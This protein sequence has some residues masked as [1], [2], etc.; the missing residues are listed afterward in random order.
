MDYP[1]SPWNA[2]AA[3]GVASSLKAQGKT[4]EATTKYEDITKRFASSPIIDEAKLSLARLYEGS[5]A[6]E[7][8]KLYDDLMKGNPRQTEGFFHGI[9]HLL[10]KYLGMNIE[11]E[12][13]TTRGSADAVV[14]TNTHVYIFEFKIGKTTE[15]AMTQLKTR[16]Y[17]SKY[18][19]TRKEIIGVAMNFNRAIREF[20]AWQVEILGE[21]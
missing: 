19:A 9:I 12:V 2:Q 17:A 5:K 8:F 20:D 10:F 1:D 3:L 15:I 16:N 13:H 14:Q 7:A 4:A 21:N 11:S 6:E 18:R